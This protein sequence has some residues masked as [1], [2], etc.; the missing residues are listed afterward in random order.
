ML[1]ICLTHDK[2]QVELIS[3]NQIIKDFVP[4]F[5]PYK[6]KR[7]LHIHRKCFI[8]KGVKERIRT[9]DLLT[10]SQAL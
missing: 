1:I 9:A 4:Y 10:A 3:K 2:Q 6:T 7:H 5:V 8:I